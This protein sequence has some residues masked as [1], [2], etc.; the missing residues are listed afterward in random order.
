MGKYAVTE[1]T[2]RVL[3]DWVLCMPYMGKE[4]ETRTA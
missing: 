1:C 4:L 2:C 3:C